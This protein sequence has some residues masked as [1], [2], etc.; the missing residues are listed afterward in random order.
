MVVS[1][2]W[3]LINIAIHWLYTDRSEVTLP[4]YS[5]QV[6]GKK[7][8]EDK[9]V[10]RTRLQYSAPRTLMYHGR[11]KARITSRHRLGQVKYLRKPLKQCN[12]T[13]FHTTTVVSMDGKQ[14]WGIE[15]VPA[16][17]VQPISLSDGR[18]SLTIERI[19]V[20][21]YTESFVCV[22]THSAVDTKCQAKKRLKVGCG[23]F[24]HRVINRSGHRSSRLE[25]LWSDNWYG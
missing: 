24:R 22:T 16:C 15:S 3:R 14:K 6:A 12:L 2:I 7:G 13:V 21:L 4:Q 18:R 19:G 9:V 20:H 8:Q 23:K 1:R 17:W 25:I 5:V 10:L 11:R